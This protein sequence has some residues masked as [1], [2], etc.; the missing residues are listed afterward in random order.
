M[1]T[2]QLLFGLEY[3]HQ[4]KIMHRDIKVL[5]TQILLILF[6]DVLHA[7]NSLKL[8]MCLLIRGQTFLLITRVALNLLI[9]VH[10]RKLLHWYNIFFNFSNV[11]LSA[12]S[13]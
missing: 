10:P 13:S 7:H 12:I 1:Y 11:S 4:N 5:F 6:L 3:L 2:K 8:I 9:L